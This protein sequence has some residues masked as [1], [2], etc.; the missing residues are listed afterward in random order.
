LFI[1]ALTGLRTGQV[2]PLALR[3]QEE[4]LR[5]VPTSRFNRLLQEAIDRHPPPAH[6]GRQLKVYFGA[7][8]RT[9][10]PT[11]EIQVNDPQRVHF[12]YARYLENQLRQAFG[13]LGTPIE[14][15]FRGRDGTA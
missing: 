14:L 1:S 3:V 8:S 10:P 5:R 12:T 4:A 13:F 7:Q 11:F 6:A 9:A 15:R 2:L